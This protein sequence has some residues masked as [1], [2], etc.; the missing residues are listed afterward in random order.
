[1]LD[2]LLENDIKKWAEDYLAT[3]VGGQPARSLL[4]GIRALFGGASSDQ[5]PLA[6]AVSS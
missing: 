5:A 4:A 1:M 2:H 3:L 6:L